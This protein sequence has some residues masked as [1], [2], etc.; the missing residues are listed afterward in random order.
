MIASG[1]PERWLAVTYAFKKSRPAL[2]ALFALDISLGRVVASTTEPMIGAMRLAW[3]REALERLHQPPI[4]GEPVLQA[5]AAELVHGRP[6]MAA[7]LAA[8]VEGWVALIEVDRLD[9][10]ALQTHAR[11][12]GQ[13]LFALAA[14]ALD[15]DRDM[16]VIERLGRGWALVDLASRLSQTGA[17]MEAAA[18]AADVLSDRP[19]SLP[20]RARP[21]TALATL[22][23]RDA[24]TRLRYR[25]VGSPGR[26]LRMLV[27]L[28]TG[29]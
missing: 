18:M 19:R 7:Q 6:E 17:R 2:A 10:E 12:R 3:W 11:E 23:R 21:L 28:L 22:A 24:Q 9:T 26:Q 13:R 29:R 25:R 16:D 20:R 1:D 4:P 14:D 5:L 27:A 8:M 15:V